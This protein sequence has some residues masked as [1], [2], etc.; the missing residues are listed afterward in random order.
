M[1]VIAGFYKNR[2]RVTPLGAV[3]AI[4]GGGGSAALISRLFDIKYMDLG[5]L[6]ISVVLLFVAS[7]ID[8]KIKSRKRLLNL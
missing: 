1:P 5:S 3:V 6:L 8:D 2:L 7:F 4:A